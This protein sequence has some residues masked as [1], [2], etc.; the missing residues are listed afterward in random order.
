MKKRVIAFAGIT[1]A[2]IAQGAVY[3]APADIDTYKQKTD[4]NFYDMYQNPN[5][6]IA[7]GANP[8]LKSLVNN[9]K[10]GN[11]IAYG[12]TIGKVIQG[13]VQGTPIKVG[14]T[15]RGYITGIG[16]LTFQVDDK[17]NVKLYGPYTTSDHTKAIRENEQ[18]VPISTKCVKSHT[19]GF[20]KV[21][22]TACILYERQAIE[23]IFDINNGSFIQRKVKQLAKQNCQSQRTGKYT[24]T[25]TCRRKPFE[26]TQTYKITNQSVNV[27]DVLKGKQ[28]LAINIDKKRIDYSGEFTDKIDNRGK[29]LKNHQSNRL[30]LINP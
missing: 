24:G 4:Q 13:S 19:W 16:T 20:G 7:K 3:I 8:T 28:K 18:A 27:A 17:G 9:V 2:T 12:N 23:E 10:T 25:V 1:S 30:R 6:P 29:I 22:R 15:A 26:T 11:K 5:S 21:S 14:T